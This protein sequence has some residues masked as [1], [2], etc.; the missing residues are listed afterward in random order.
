MTFAAVE[1]Q[2][3][4]RAPRHEEEDVRDPRRGGGE[5]GII[6]QRAAIV[7]VHQ[8]DDLGGGQSLPKVGAARQHRDQS[9][10]R[11]RKKDQQRDR[12]P[13]RYED[14]SNGPLAHGRD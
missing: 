11:D 10:H 4:Q 3:S 7:T 6:R 5:E 1:C 9:G 14:R 13:T 8:R 2:K 12:D